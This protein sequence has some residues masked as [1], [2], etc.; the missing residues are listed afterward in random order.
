MNSESLPFALFIP[1][2]R[3]AH[4]SPEDAIEHAVKHVAELN[5]QI[6]AHFK[7]AAVSIVWSTVLN[8]TPRNEPGIMIQA[9]VTAPGRANEP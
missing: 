1:S 7:G 3:L 2:A 4:G 6:E 8:P 9:D 5:R